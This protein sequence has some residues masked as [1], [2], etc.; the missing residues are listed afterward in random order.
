M[1]YPH[2]D[3][4]TDEQADEVKRVGE[5]VTE[6]LSSVET[7]EPQ[8]ALYVVLAATVF[9]YHRQ[10]GLGVEAANDDFQRVLF[11]LRRP[12]KTDLS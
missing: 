9:L 6:I 4:L 12:G 8:T 11:A 2:P 10:D 3:D 1:K 7:L 5:A